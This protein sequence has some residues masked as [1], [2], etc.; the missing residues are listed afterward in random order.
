[1]PDVRLKEV[2]EL[3][4]MHF[5]DLHWWPGDPP[6]EVA[7]GAIL[8]QNTSWKN[9]EKAIGALKAHGVLD[10]HLL[11]ALS[12]KKLGVLIRPAGFYNLKTKRIKSFLDFLHGE[13]GGIMEEMFHENLRTLR[14]KLLSVKGI[15][16]ETADSILLY[17]GGKPVFVVDAYTR[18]I[19]LRHTIINEE[20]G[21]GEIQKLFMES[22]PRKA[23]LYNQY[24]AL[25]VH[26]GKIYCRK[27]PLCTHCPLNVL[28]R[29]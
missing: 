7:I 25:F 6:F 15:G 28:A 13:Y 29:T 14:R 8:T 22:L 9:V 1:M 16:D 12:D 24:H 5:G 3:L 21:Y 26:T 2:Y 20:N 18:R 27:E 19:L 4:D 23:S 10:P 17:A 11:A